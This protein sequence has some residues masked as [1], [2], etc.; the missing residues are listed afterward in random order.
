MV[1]NAIYGYI[2]VSHKQGKTKLKDF[3]IKKN[4]DPK[5]R[6]IQSNRKSF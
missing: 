5:N 2:Q 3:K 4:A 6:I 1:I